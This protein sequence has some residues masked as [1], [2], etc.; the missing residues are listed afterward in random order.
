MVVKFK[1]H[2]EVEEEVVVQEVDH[3]LEFIINIKGLI[4]VNLISNKIVRECKNSL[5]TTSLN[6]NKLNQPQKK[7]SQ[8]NQ[9]K[10][11]L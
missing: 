10:R 3:L 1:I 5:I 4:K 9:R 11:N 2:Q 6:Q 7:F 8:D